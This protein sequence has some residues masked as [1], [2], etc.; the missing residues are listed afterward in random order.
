MDVSVLDLGSHSFQLL[1][2]RSSRADRVERLHKDIEF[3]ELTNFLSPLGSINKEGFAAGIRG[4]QLLLQRAPDSAH[5]RPLIAIATSAIREASNGSDFLV[6]LEQA[7][8]VAAR[9][10]S[11]DD[12]A[13]FAYSGAASEF[14]GRAVR[15][16]VVDLGGGSTELAWG[17]GRQ[18]VHAVSVRL[19]V[20]SLV[21]RLARMPN[22]ANMALDQLAVFVR[23]TLEPVVAAAEQEPPAVLVFASGVAR[24]IQRL[25]VSYEV[26]TPEA[27]ITARALRALIP[28]L[29]DATPDELQ[30]RGVPPQRVRTAG[31]TAIV[32]DVV[33]ELFEKEEFIVARGGLREGAVL[34]ARKLP[35]QAWPAQR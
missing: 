32:L 26:A 28:L 3:V 1:Y 30:A 7:T 5:K 20:M 24:V 35:S 22:T 16:A 23:R 14:D 8:G 21:E 31:P 17:T 9:V 13:R 10:I 6:A 4:V 34:G 2:A 18:L 11:G 12:E 33:C 25:A 29:L 19:G 15:L 27:P